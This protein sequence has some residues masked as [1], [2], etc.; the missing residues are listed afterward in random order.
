MFRFRV[1]IAALMLAGILAHAT[2]GV[3]HDFA[4]AQAN[5]AT[6]SLETA[7]TEICSAADGHAASSTSTS[8]STSP[9]VPA[10]PSPAKKVV[11]CTFCMPSGPGTALLPAGKV[12]L[13][14]SER[15]LVLLALI[16]T[17][18]APHMPPV[19]PPSQGPPARV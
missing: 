13:P 3:H 11:E 1:C 7:L 14:P 16:G 6:Q 19:R 17:P 15:P 10:A 2:F 18:A 9:A 4:M 8:T 5:A 12:L